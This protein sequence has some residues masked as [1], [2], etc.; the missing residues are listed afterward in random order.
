MTSIA[1]ITV[2]SNS[3]ELKVGHG[4]HVFT[5]TNTY[6]ETLTYGV[7]AV[8][9]DRRQKVWFKIDGP[10]ERQL[11]VR[12][13]DQISVNIEADPDVAA[14]KYT[15]HLL[16]YSTRNPGEDFTKSPT[17]AFIVK[18][19]D[20]EHKNNPPAKSWLPMAALATGIVAVLLSLITFFY[21]S[22]D[23]KSVRQELA[24]SMGIPGKNISGIENNGAGNVR[25]FTAGGT[26]AMALLNSNQWADFPEL[27]IKLELDKESHVIAFYQI[28]MAGSNS[29]LVT[30]LVVD[31]KDQRHTRSITGNTVYWSPASLWSNKLA[32]GKHTITVQYRTPKGGQNHPAGDDWQNRTLTAIVLGG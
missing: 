8:P 27:S 22:N 20:P 25:V 29:H 17:V 16:V 30:R 21:L 1:N 32:K 23:M 3:V 6:S 31:G 5:V 28:V 9:D 7:K 13:S 26:S 18:E 2:A 10:K 14:G 11:A 24:D 12:Q 19:R 4:T 15:F